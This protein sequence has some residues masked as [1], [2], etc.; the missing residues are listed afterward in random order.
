[1]LEVSTLERQE[2]KQVINDCPFTRKGCDCCIYLKAA[3]SWWCTNKECIKARGTSLPGI[4][5]CPYWAPHPQHIAEH[6]MKGLPQ[7]PR[8]N[9]LKRLFKIKR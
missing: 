3:L 2:K 5:K 4:I 7:V 8:I 6:Y 1:M 9:L